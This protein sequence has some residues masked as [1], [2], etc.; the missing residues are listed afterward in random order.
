MNTRLLRIFRKLG[1]S[2]VSPRVFYASA[3]V[4]LGTTIVGSR[5]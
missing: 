5:T 4:L 3:M 1:V 2:L